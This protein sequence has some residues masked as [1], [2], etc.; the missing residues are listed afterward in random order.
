MYTC[1]GCASRSK[2]TLPALNIFKLSVDTGI[3]LQVQKNFLNKLNNQLANLYIKLTSS[4]NSRLVLSHLAVALISIVLMAFFS[5]RYIFQAAYA[6]TE[7]NL[8]D[9]AFA[10]SN[11][12]QLPIME[13]GEGTA[14]PQTIKEMLYRMLADN[15]EMRFTVFKPDGSPLVDSSETLPPHVSRL[16]APE[17]IDALESDIGRGVNIR[18]GPGGRSYMYLAV[19]VQ[20]EIEV[21]GILRL[22]M[23]MEP[24][25]QAARR[26]FLI[27]MGVAV[28]IAVG[29][30][31]FGWILAKN[32]ARP[33]QVLTKAA[34]NMERGDLSVRV[35]PSGP[36]ELHRLA[37]AFNSMANRLQ[38]NVNELRAFVA[39]A[40]H[41]LRTPLTVVKLR[42]EA[43]RGGALEDSEVAER[44]LE[45]VETEVDRLVRMVNDLLDLSRMEAGLES[46][47]PTRIN[48]SAIAHDVYDTFSIRAARADVNLKL[49]VETDLPAVTGNEDQ[50][51]R[52]FY[53][54]LE[55]AIKYTPGNGQVEMLLR[56]G[57][58]SKSVR[59]LV[60]D[61]GPGIAPEHL[62][63]V[64]ERFYR[65]ETSQQRPGVP[66]GSGLGLAI[67]KSIVESHGGEMG[68]SS[69]V[70]NG[71]TFWADL[72]IAV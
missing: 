13:A 65:A 27:L 34:E 4:L 18:R 39:N 57:P 32:L 3:A 49:D 47:K 52:V 5:G 14:D 71:T 35:K 45:E 15:V 30:S 63:H 60:R 67:A 11:A 1:A 22:A 55:N 28:L 43:L 48:L 2:K 8:Q 23:P 26:S 64:F 69:Q 33:I 29:V 21:I 62:P 38:S 58:N 66:R 59:L 9:L 42:T 46:G 37:E 16:N 10:M 68:V 36:Q 19:L 54:L 31:L 20:R 17:V 25:Q 53:N 6:E 41:E 51:R 40:S 70:G 56:L 24:T 44:F 72:P 12:I 7:H 61:S 50:I